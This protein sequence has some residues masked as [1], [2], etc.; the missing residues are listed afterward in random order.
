[1]RLIQVWLQTFITCPI[2]YT[3]IQFMNNII[4]SATVVTTK[5]ILIAQLKN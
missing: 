4:H 5:Q 1:M 3:C 2:T